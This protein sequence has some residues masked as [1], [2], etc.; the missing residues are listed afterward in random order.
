MDFVQQEINKYKNKL[1]SLINNLINTQSINE[2]IYFNKEIKKESDHL[3]SLLNIKQNNILNQ[4]NNMNMNLNPFMFQSNLFLNAPQ[5]NI[6]PNPINEQ[7]LIQ[8][9]IINIFFKDGISGE[10][11]TIKCNPQDKFSDIIRNFKVISNNYDDNIFLFNAKNLDINSNLSI[12]NMG[13]SNFAIITYAKKQY[14]TN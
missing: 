4:N 10:E 6:N 13:I 1:L 2:E 3:V 12:K 9:N 14:E 5:I 7:P 11:Y 8:N